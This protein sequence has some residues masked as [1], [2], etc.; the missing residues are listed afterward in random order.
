MGA[1]RHVWRAI[2]DV[3][4]PQVSKLIRVLLQGTGQLLFELFHVLCQTLRELL[5]LQYR[6]K[7]SA[8][9]DEIA[10]LLVELLLSLRSIAVLLQV[11]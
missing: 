6:R 10:E 5:A 9:E 3:G 7:R 2:Y 1:N 8:I 11:P 4:H